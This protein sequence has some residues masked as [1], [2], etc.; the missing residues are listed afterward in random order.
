MQVDR[1]KLPSSYAPYS[2]WNS[3]VLCTGSSM[4]L[5]C[6]S[7]HL[8][9]LND[10]MCLEKSLFLGSPRINRFSHAWSPHGD[11]VC[12]AYGSHLTLYDSNFSLLLQQELSFFGRHVAMGVN[13][14][15]VSTSNGAYWYQWTTNTLKQIAHV[16]KEIPVTCAMFSACGQWAALG[17]ADGRVQIYQLDTFSTFEILLPSPRITSIS[18]HGN[19]IVFA[20]K[21]GHADTFIYNG[22]SWTR[23]YSSIRCV[24]VPA[25]NAFQGYP[26]ST[27]VA[28]YANFLAVAHSSQYVDLIEMES[29]RCVERVVFPAA[30][31]MLGFTFHP[32]LGLILHDVSGE[33]F[34]LTWKHAHTMLQLT[35]ETTFDDNLH[36]ALRLGETGVMEIFDSV[37]DQWIPAPFI[38]PI[39]SHYDLN[40]LPWSTF[41]VIQSQQILAVVLGYAVFALDNGQWK[42]WIAPTGISCAVAVDGRGTNFSFFSHRCL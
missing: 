42:H 20:T 14:I 41:Q 11:Y 30:T 5:A 31:M 39:S 32:S 2:S 17:A 25:L 27:L 6:E 37:Q 35:H 29:G 12:V 1:V 16:F 15:I 26:S 28:F 22:E 4:S 19:N 21:D 40:A 33:L 10:R 9:V 36:E 7:G 3:S 23:R 13:H 24:A 8:H 34:I 18:F 38:S